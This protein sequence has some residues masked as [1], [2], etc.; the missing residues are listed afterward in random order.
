MRT[1][2]VAA[3][4]ETAIQNQHSVL[5]YG[6]LGTAK[7]SLVE[8]T[9]ESLDYDLEIFHPVVSDPTDFKGSPGL[10]TARG[11][12]LILS[13]LTVC[14]CRNSRILCVTRLCTMPYRI[15]RGAVTRAQVIKKEGE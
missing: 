14:H 12:I 3:V 4:L 7:T 11:F 10:W 9:A 8:Q 15:I 13:G 1:K 2:D 6:V 5:M